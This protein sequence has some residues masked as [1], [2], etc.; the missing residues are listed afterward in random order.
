[1][2]NAGSRS[3]RGLR[4][5]R[6]AGDAGVRQRPILRPLVR[7][8]SSSRVSCATS[9]YFGP[10]KKC[11][12]SHYT[13][14]L[15]N[16][17]TDDQVQTKT[18]FRYAQ[19]ELAMKSATSAGS[20]THPIHGIGRAARSKADLRAAARTAYATARLREAAH[21]V[22]ELADE[23]PETA[24]NEYVGCLL[25]GNRPTGISERALHTW[26]A[27]PVTIFRWNREVGIGSMP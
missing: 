1:M 6:V 18:Q 26:V 21:A 23:L 17:P 7:I 14:A 24:A 12:T 25:L 3:R 20:G 27:T 8:G 19:E 16:P 5:G 11:G 4:P 9:D 22:D 10:G 15:G 13:R 2:P